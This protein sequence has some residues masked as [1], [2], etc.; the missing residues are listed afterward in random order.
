MS[1]M[2]LAF[3]VLA[4][5]MASEARGTYVRL[6]FT[7]EFGALPPGVEYRL[8]CIDATTGVIV[9][10]ELPLVPGQ[11]YRYN[12]PQANHDKLLCIV[13][14]NGGPTVGVWRIH[15]KRYYQG[16]SEP[17]TADLPS[18]TGKCGDGA[19]S[20][21]E[22]CD[23]TG[24]AGCAAGSSKPRCCKCEYCGCAQDADC[25]PVTS[26]PCGYGR[27]A[28]TERPVIT[29]ACYPCGIC[30]Y[31]YRCHADPTCVEGANPTA[32]GEAALP[33]DDAAV[34]AALAPGQAGTLYPG[35]AAYQ[36]A[37][38]GAALSVNG[39]LV[40]A[41]PGSACALAEGGVVGFLDTPL[42]DIRFWLAGPGA[43]RAAAEEW[44]AGEGAVELAGRGNR[45]CLGGV[46][47][48]VLDRVRELRGVEL[49]N[50]LV[51][52]DTVYAAKARNGDVRSLKEG[53][54]GTPTLKVRTDRG[55]VEAVLEGELTVKQAI[56]AGRIVVRRP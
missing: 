42:P 53:Y 32:T 49:V 20:G 38:A 35:E 44:L 47:E 43:V 51:A 23:V 39:V 50:L 55:T 27:C 17:V 1:R 24:N 30:I 10:T 45:G 14:V 56:A 48:G 19:V 4:T 8:Q 31:P 34:H 54:H 2:L 37:N 26:P 9:Y 6:E 13:H 40:P 36:V 16:C 28:P 46:L 22:A 15:P 7:F 41:L 52:G 11:K 18:D 21:I 33:V 25:P 12:A 3:L 29:P 5:V